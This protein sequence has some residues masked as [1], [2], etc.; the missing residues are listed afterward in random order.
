MQYEFK[1]PK[2]GKIE[3]YSKQSTV[4]K[5]IAKG[6]LCQNCK[7]KERQAKETY[8]RTCPKCGKEIV[9]KYRS[10]YNK[11]VKRNSLCKH[12]AVSKSSIFQKGHTLNQTEEFK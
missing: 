3:Y 5:K 7:D 1:C 12:C 8:I 4:D 2:C 9:Y 11:A 10:D 6:D